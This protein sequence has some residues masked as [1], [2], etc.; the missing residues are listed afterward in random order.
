MDKLDDATSVKPLKSKQM[1]TIHMGRSGGQ[2]RTIY[3]L[4]L[5]MGHLKS[6]SSH[7]INN[8]GNIG[9]RKQPHP[10]YIFIEMLLLSRLIN[11]KCNPSKESDPGNG[12]KGRRVSVL[13]KKVGT[14]DNTDHT[15]AEHNQAGCRLPAVERCK[16]Q[17]CAQTLPDTCPSD[18]TV[19]TPSSL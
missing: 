19:Y 8:K 4:V 12:W 17:P 13:P 9:Y 2:P 7:G 6:Q 14:A 1:M 16:P 10:M 5:M 18:M 15:A 3:N 11:I